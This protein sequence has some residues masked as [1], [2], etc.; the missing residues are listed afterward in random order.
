M[1][2][3]MEK[4]DSEREHVYSQFK[5]WS[6]LLSF[7]VVKQERFKTLFSDGVNIFRVPAEYR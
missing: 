2:N 7:F 5:N 4:K 3:M 6:K 1:N